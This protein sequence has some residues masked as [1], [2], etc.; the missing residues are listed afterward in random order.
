VSL[1][2][3]ASEMLECSFFLIFLDCRI[4][5]FWTS[6]IISW[7]HLLCDNFPCLSRL[8]LEEQV[9]HQQEEQEQEQEQVQELE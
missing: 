7:V 6:I 1:F 9:G 5:D 3:L 8:R 4:S 2:G